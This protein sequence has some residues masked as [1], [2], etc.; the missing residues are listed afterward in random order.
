MGPFSEA[1][2]VEEY[3]NEVKDVMLE[4]TQREE[5]KYQETGQIPLQ[6]EVL[7]NDF[8]MLKGSN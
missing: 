4:G 2:I 6:Q 3:T 8:L 7:A 5:T 1:E